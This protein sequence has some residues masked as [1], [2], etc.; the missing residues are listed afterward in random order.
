MTADYKTETY[1]GTGEQDII[2]RS[3][4][5]SFSL[6]VKAGVDD[7][8]DIQVVLQP[9]NIEGTPTRYTVRSGVSGNFIE[10]FIGPVTGVA[11]NITTN[12]STS[13]KTEMLTSYRF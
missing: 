9:A 7:V 12:V 10:T 4:E 11:L 3:A 2:T 8:Y 5:K 6:A 13:I 1:T